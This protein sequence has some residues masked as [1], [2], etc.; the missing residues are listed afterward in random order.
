MVVLGFQ[1]LH[2]KRNV[3]TACFTLF[4]KLTSKQISCSKFEHS[5]NKLRQLFLFKVALANSIQSSKIAKKSHYSCFSF[6]LLGI[7]IKQ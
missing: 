1:E 2:P 4:H 5:L 7:F 3:H 6:Y